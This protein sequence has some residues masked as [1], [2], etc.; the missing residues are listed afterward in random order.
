MIES[1]NP[2]PRIL[3]VSWGKLEVEERAEPY[4]DAKLFPGGSR[5]WNWRDTGTSHR[6]GIQIADVQALAY[7]RN[8]WFVSRQLRWPERS[9]SAG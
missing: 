5:E 8:A 3:H 4:K 7:K 6:P 1:R 2:S 9:D